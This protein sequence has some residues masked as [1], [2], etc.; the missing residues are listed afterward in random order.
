M[1]DMN[2]KKVK[3]LQQVPF[4]SVTQVKLS[5]VLKGV[6]SDIELLQILNEL[7]V[8]GVVEM[9]LGQR[10]PEFKRRWN[11]SIDE[12]RKALSKELNSRFPSDTIFLPRYEGYVAN[13]TDN[14]LDGVCSDA[15]E[16]FGEFNDEYV[17]WHRNAKTNV[18]YPPKMYA[19]NSSCV[20]TCNVLNGMRIDPSQVEYAVEFEVIAPEEMK[21]RPG[22]M[23]APKAFFDCIVNYQDA[24]EFVQ[25]N[26]LDA[27]FCPFRQSMWAYQFGSRYL[28]EDENAIE[29]WRDAA[30]RAH[31][32]F[33][34]GYETL[35][36]LIAMYS[37]I[38]ANPEDYQNKAVKLINM[39][40]KTSVDTKYKA[41]GSF[42]QDYLEEGKKAEQFFNGILA[43]LPLP[44][45]TTL[46]FEFMTI[47]DILESLDEEAKAYITNRYLNF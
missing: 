27:F 39:N 30:R 35:K 37:D 26:F 45:G 31:F 25:T 6:V 17:R 5:E 24:V 33:F 41:I 34:D 8:E 14:F 19:L 12:E 13:A 38:L 23:S 4:V 29:I 28:F 11:S 3:V 16:A 44:E 9:N 1:S 40:W 42:M 10:G 46:S 21:D 22:E 36:T 20:L 15:F 2:E 32:V 47:E 7:V 18:L 43:N